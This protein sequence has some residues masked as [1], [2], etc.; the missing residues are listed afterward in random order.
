MTDTICRADASTETAADVAETVTLEGRSAVRIQAQGTHPTGAIE[1]LEPLCGGHRWVAHP[2]GQPFSYQY[3]AV[4]DSMLSLGR[5][6]F[7]GALRG[8]VPRTDDYIVQWI[9]HGHGTLTSHSDR[10]DL[11]IG[12]PVLL[13]TE[14]AFAFEYQDYDQRLVHLSRTLVEDVAA[15]RF[16]I[17]P[18]TD[19][20]LD[21]LRPVVGP[22]MLRWIRHV[23]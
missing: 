1:D 21:A 19:L 14:E 13:P 11:T 23:A 7:S 18:G 9:A 12:V 4:G 5:C 8:T 15:E 16:G 6:R 20:G 22:L 17:Q 2:T 3:T 10:I